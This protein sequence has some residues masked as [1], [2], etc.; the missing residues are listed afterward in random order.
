MADRS[1]AYAARAQIERVRVGD[2]PR[3]CYELYGTNA[4]DLV[5][6]Y[7]HGGYWRA[8]DIETH[9]FLMPGLSRIGGVQASVE[10]RLMPGA[11]LTDLIDDVAKALLDIAG[12]LT[13]RLVVIGHSA[14]GHLSVAATR[15]A[16]LGD[17]VAAIVPISGLFDL[18]PLQWCFLQ[19]E[20]GLT[21]DEIASSPLRQ[22]TIGDPPMLI[23][24]G[25]AETAE[26]QRQAEAMASQTGSPVIRI[27]AAHHLTLLNALA[28]P[29]APFSKAI[30][31]FLAGRSI[32]AV[33]EPVSA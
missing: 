23:A 1:A 14:G 2:D 24:V 4:G 21:A 8:L 26:Y 31:D 12:R 20:I 29:D 7:I 27:G 28:G 32:P 13:G 19:D 10:Y 30:A 5:P 18:E 3:Q 16:G 17:R 33:T 22:P 9:R 11:R 25:E 15:K 6:V